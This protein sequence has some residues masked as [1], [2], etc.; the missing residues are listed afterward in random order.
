M[1]TNKDVLKALFPLE[2]GGVFDD[3]ITLEGQELDSAQQNA[4]LLLTEIFPETSVYL[5]S[6]WERIYGIYPEPGETLQQRQNAVLQA[7]RARG[8]LS[9]AY[10][11][12]MAASLGYTIT[13]SEYKPFMAGIGRAGDSI[14]IYDSIFAF[15]VTAPSVNTYFF[16]AGQSC[17]G[18]ALGAPNENTKI[19]NL[20]NKLKPA[21]TFAAFNYI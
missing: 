11:V 10:L 2:L 20:I 6:S 7:V 4:E 15:Q 12:S 14:Y 16:R 17:A 21:H 13:I 9:I 5:L 1:S 3:D 8:G 18:E 19:T